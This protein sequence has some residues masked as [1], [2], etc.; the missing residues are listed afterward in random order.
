MYDLG[1]FGR[2]FD[3]TKVGKGLRI[4]RFPKTASG[5]F[6]F[7][8][9]RLIEKEGDTFGKMFE[10]TFVVLESNNELVMV[11][12]TYTKAFFQGASKVDREKC[13]R[14]LLPLLLSAVGADP[15]DASA[16]ENA[17]DTLGELLEL[18]TD[19]DATATEPAR[20]GTDLD[21]KVRLSVKL[22]QARPD[23]E[24]NK[25]NPKFLNDDGSPKI[26]AEDTW[27]RAV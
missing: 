15:T 3:A 20:L 13:W 27:S 11:G 24:T 22:E 19:K 17:P 25:V 14:K 10:A 23:K 4:P 7:D 26:F 21:L 1:D 2:S 6:K 12:G 8:L 5:N 16:L 18:S 9:K